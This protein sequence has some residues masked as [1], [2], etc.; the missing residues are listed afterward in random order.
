MSLICGDPDS[1]GDGWWYRVA[2]DLAPLASKRAKRCCS[3]GDLIKVGAP[4]RRFNRARNPRTDIEERIYCCDEVSLAAW[5]M[6]EECSDLYDNLIAF[7]YHITLSWGEEM[8]GLLEIHA[9]G[10]YD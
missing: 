10:S 9:T 7:G 3:C 6:C 4:S 1:D 5:H 8:R 2:P